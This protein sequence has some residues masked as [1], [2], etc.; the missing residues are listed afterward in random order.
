MTEV[1]HKRLP[2]GEEAILSTTSGLRAAPRV[3]D[4]RVVW[5]DQNGYIQF[6]DLAAKQTETI[7]ETAYGNR[8]PLPFA[9][10]LWWYGYDYGD[11][12]N[13]GLMAY[14]VSSAQRAPTLVT[15]MD[16]GG[17][18]S[19]GL[20][21]MGRGQPFALGTKR[22]V[23]SRWEPV[24]EKAVEWTFVVHAWPHAGTEAPALALDPERDHIRPML[25]AND[26]LVTENYLHSEGCTVSNCNL[27]LTAY[28]TNGTPRVLAPAAKPTLLIDPVVAGERIVWLD[29]RDGLYQLWAVDVAQPAKDAVRITSEKARIGTLST[30]AASTT[31]GVVWADRR[32]GQWRLYSRAW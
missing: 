32:T 9:G 11:W 21:G 24:D 8:T 3:G 6:H 19:G 1:R 2:N 25:T 20:N 29:H 17:W 18:G 7:A 12:N 22:V 10:R 4:G 28:P 16:D 27:A 14:D 5:F 23:W 30:F 13:W 15:Q 26:T 31:R